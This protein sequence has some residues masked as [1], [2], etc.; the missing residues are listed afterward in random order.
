MLEDQESGR[1]ITRHLTD[2]YPIKPTGNF[3]NL[4]QTQRDANLQDVEED[5]GGL[6][7]SKLHKISLEGL[8]QAESAQEAEINK[9]Q[10]QQ[11]DKQSPSGQQ[12]PRKQS[13]GQENDQ[14]QWSSRLRTRKK[15][16][17]K[18]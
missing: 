10:Q 18:E 11:E 17:Y 8:E 14:A 1:R 2:V 6:K 15:V 3:S 5:F 13:G 12:S 4:F 16:S 7:A 9:Q